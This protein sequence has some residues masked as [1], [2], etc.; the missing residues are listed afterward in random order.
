MANPTRLV[1][2]DLVPPVLRKYMET[3]A[4]MGAEQPE[5]DGL[6]VRYDAALADQFISTL[7]T[8]GL[9]R[10]EAILGIIPKADASAEDRRRDISMALSAR[11]PHTHRTL[12]QQL[13]ILCGRGNY[14][15]RIDY[16]RYTIVIAIELSAKHALDKTAEYL[17]GVVPANMVVV[18]SLRYTTHEEVS[19]YTHAQLAAYRH[20]QIKEEVL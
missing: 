8:I 4:I 11:L 15:L 1:L 3:Q 18:L 6:W 9:L 12:E 5:F 17:R 16:N 20:I 7:G 13:D 2:L 14:T 10:W 19:R